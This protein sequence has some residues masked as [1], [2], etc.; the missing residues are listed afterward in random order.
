MIWMHQHGKLGIRTNVVTGCRCNCDRYNRLNKPKW[1]PPKWLFG[2]AWG[3][4]YAAQ[5]YSG[6]LVLHQVF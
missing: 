3:V 2:P 4:M 5:S 6:W 1:T